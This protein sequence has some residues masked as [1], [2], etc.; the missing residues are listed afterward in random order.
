MNPKLS[1]ERT[2]PSTYI[3]V[4]NITRKCK[5]FSTNQRLIIEVG[6]HVVRNRNHK[7]TDLGKV[8]LITSLT[9]EESKLD[10]VAVVAARNIVSGWHNDLNTQGK[11]DDEATY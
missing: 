2:G 1:R 6:S 3:Q 9:F 7:G 8:A 4:S 10:H 5:V 11:T